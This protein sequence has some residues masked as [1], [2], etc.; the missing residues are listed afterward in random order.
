MKQPSKERGCERKIKLDHRYE[1]QAMRLAEK[2]GKAYGVYLC[3]HCGHHHLTT[4]IENKK[5]YRKFVFETDWH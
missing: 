4:K 1:K 5:K 3:P 2:H